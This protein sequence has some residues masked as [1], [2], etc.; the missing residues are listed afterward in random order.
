MSVDR[1]PAPP[2]L[3]PRF[4]E[5]TLRAPLRSSLAARSRRVANPAL[6]KASAVLAPLF[7]R[8]GETHVLLVR[9]AHGMRDHSGQ[10]AFPGGK[11]DPADDSLLATALREAEE[12]IGL[13][14]ADVDVLGAF[15]DFPTT[16]G[17]VITPYVGWIREESVRGLTLNAAEV[18]RVFASPLRAFLETPTGTFP[19]MGW[20]IDGEFLWGATAAIVVGLVSLAK[21]L[22]PEASAPDAGA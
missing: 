18:A 16:T 8:D 5:A 20:T 7:E 11:L 3:P 17:F 21:E 13:A 6:G 1:P 2:V 10:V 15:D 12:E 22:T 9:R 19:R 4:R 14:R